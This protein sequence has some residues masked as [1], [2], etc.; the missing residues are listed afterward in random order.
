MTGRFPAFTCAVG[1]IPQRFGPARLASAAATALLIVAGI[2]V[3][4]PVAGQDNTADDAVLRIVARKLANGKIEFGLQQRQTDDSWGDRLLP[5]ARLFPTNAA[6]GRWLYSSPLDLDVNEVR[7]AARKRPDGRI[8]FGLQQRQTNRSWADQQLPSRRFFPAETAVGRWLASSPL[9]VAA[10]R[11][12]PSRAPGSPTLLVDSPYYVY[13]SSTPTGEGCVINHYVRIE[14]IRGG[15]RHSDFFAGATSYTISP[16]RL[17]GFVANWFDAFTHGQRDRRFDFEFVAEGCPRELGPIGPFTITASGP[18][19]TTPAVLDLYLFVYDRGSGIVGADTGTPQLRLPATSPATVYLDAT[20]LDLG[21][22]SLVTLDSDNARHDLF[23]GATKYEVTPSSHNGIS[24]S[25]RHRGDVCY[26]NEDRSGAWCTPG[27]VDL[28]LAASNW[29]ATRGQ[30]PVGT[31]ASFTLTA[32]GDPNAAPAT[33]ELTVVVVDETPEGTFPET[34]N[35][36]TRVVLGGPP[37]VGDIPS[38]CE[39]VPVEESDRACRPATVGEPIP[40]GRF[41]YE[42]PADL[43]AGSVV[44]FEFSRAVVT[45]LFDRGEIQGWGHRWWI[46]ICVLDARR[47]WQGKPWEDDSIVGPEERFYDAVP[48][49]DGRWQIGRSRLSMPC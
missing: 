21:Q 27:S 30:L 36:P 43:Q 39:P 19:G 24:A 9:T 12:A 49:E 28:V 1:G 44:E 5:R 38:R 7:I 8:E 3:P 33:L 26:S 31:T 45:G 15:R 14:S 22:P 25:I 34:S 11:A 4:L 32:R 42:F 41:D 2:V 18:A 29:P 46:S 20:S 40:M 17:G 48:T 23:V 13:G 16:T 10:P 47:I 6:V 37:I 35:Q